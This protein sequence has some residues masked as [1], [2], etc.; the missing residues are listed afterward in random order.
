MGELKAENEKL[1]TQAREER[2]IMLREAKEAGEQIIAKAKNRHQSRLADKMIAEAQQQINN[3]RLA[4]I[5]D[6]KNRNWQTGCRGSRKSAAQ[7][8]WTATMHRTPIRQSSWL[9]K[10]RLN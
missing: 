8:S 9:P 1:M 2:S 10:F 4:A 3:Q 5:T 6:V 7:A